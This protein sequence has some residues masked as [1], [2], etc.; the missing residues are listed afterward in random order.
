M[1]PL[2][3]IEAGAYY[4]RALAQPHRK[5]F[6]YRIVN[7]SIP[8]LSSAK[9]FVALKH[10]PCYN[11][12]CIVRKTLMFNFKGKTVVVMGGTS[13][14]GRATAHAFFQAGA[15]VIAA[16]LRTEESLPPQ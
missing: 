11:G 14:L 5:E 8:G 1:A 12:A 13:G 7:L 6:Y 4:A 10:R 16:G 9:I 15:S 2:L 3:P